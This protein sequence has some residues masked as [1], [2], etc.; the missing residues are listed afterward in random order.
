MMSSQRPRAVQRVTH[1]SPWRSVLLGKADLHIHSGVSD[2]MASIADI[3]AFV[4]ETTDL[5]VV[6]ITDHDHVA[7]AL[8]A[9]RWVD[10]HPACRFRVVYGTEIT[11]TLGRHL[12]AYFFRPPYPTRPIPRGKSYSRTID[13]IHSLGGIVAVPHPTVMWTPSGGYRQMKYLLSRGVQID[14]IEVCNAAIGARNNE[15]KIRGFNTRDLHMAELGGSDAHHLAQIGAG[16]TSFKGHSLADMERAIVHRAT[17]A[18]FGEKGQVTI[19][20]HAQ[21]VFKSWVEKPTRGLRAA[22]ADW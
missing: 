20:E 2:G 6:A 8:E 3:M 17:H 4:Q 1:D 15:D 5:D 22:L 10:R 18:H 11:S 14:G 12:L 19:G 9:L 13:L 21:Q 7:G 16:Y